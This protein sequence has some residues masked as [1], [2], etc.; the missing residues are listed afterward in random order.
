MSAPSSTLS[1]HHIAPEH[2]GAALAR[3][4]ER[5]PL[6]QCMT[7]I[8]VAQWTANVLLAVGTS[9]AMVDNPDEAGAF[10]AVAHGVLVNLGTPQHETVAAMAHAVTGAAGAGT[11]WVLDPVGAGGLPWRTRVALDLLSRSAPAVIRGNASEILGLAGGQGGKGADS[12]HTP[13]AALPTA[14]ELAREHGTVV[15]VSG[16]VDHLTDGARVVRVG[17]GTELLTQVTGAGCALGALMAAFCPVVED[18]LL[19][20]TAATAT[21]TVAAEAAAGRSRGPGSFAVALLDELALLTPAALT[22]RARL[23]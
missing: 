5:P 2:L 6:V 14:A 1:D 23:S 7:N 22:E 3:L 12:E 9:P 17:N 4:R 20:A 11:P 19:A 21:L 8:V 15:A 10:A 18:P 13:E 16:A